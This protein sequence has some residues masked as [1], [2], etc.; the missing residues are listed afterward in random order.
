MCGC[1]T[2]HARMS[3]CACIPSA[4]CMLAEEWDCRRVWF[5]A[6]CWSVV[7]LFEQMIS[8]YTYGFSHLKVGP[9]QS[10]LAWLWT[11]WAVQVP[12]V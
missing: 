3:Y 5:S 1:G 9:L 10:T 2:C 6:V 7:F 12:S 4:A 11:L 8:K